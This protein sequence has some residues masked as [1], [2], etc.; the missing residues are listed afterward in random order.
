MGSHATKS[1][2]WKGPTDGKIRAPAELTDHSRRKDNLADAIT[3]MELGMLN[4]LDYRLREFAVISGLTNL[5]HKG[6]FPS[7]R[8]G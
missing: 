6:F 4:Q 5:R 2:F 8:R 3:H 7:F 1:S